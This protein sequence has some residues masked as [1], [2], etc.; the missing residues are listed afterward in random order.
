M[1]FLDNSGDIILDAVLT[2]IG[3][4][5]LAAGNFNIAKFALGDEEI[6]YALWDTSDNRGSQFY[7][8]RI[9]Q[10]PILEAFTSDQ[11][12]MKSRLMSLDRTNILWLPILRLNDTHSKWKPHSALKGFYLMADRNTYEVGL[13]GEDRDDPA[14]P[15]FLHGVQTYSADPTKYIAI[16][17]GIAGSSETLAA[18]M[19]PG[20]Y[21]PAYIVKV[22]HRLIRL[23][24]FI[25]EGQ[26]SV[27]L[28]HQSVDDD[29][30]ATYYIAQ[31]DA[32]SPVVPPTVDIDGRRRGE[33]L[34]G[35]S[36]DVISRISTFEMFDGPLGSVLRL[37]PRVAPTVAQGN[38]LFDEIGSNSS[39]ALPFRGRNI[40][41]Y[42][43]IDTTISVTGATTGFSIDV[44][45]RIL[46]GLT[47]G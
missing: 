11:S 16:D 4:K 19:P 9:M 23:E 25:G 14:N 6:N 40:L 13:T 15:G 31:S 29:S 44:P 36:D 43:Y 10:T 27:P 22:D 12:I 3:R 17:Q 42:K 1:A 47:F 28:T 32:G 20:L 41:T 8:L 35:I 45:I 46:K 33:L 24:G 37:V 34:P 38:T 21:E 7:D 39:G 18:P 26:P 2:D 30:V 5:R